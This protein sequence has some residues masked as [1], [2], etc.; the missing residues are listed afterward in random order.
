MDEK[1]I[2]LPGKGTPNLILGENEEVLMDVSQGVR[3]LG[4]MG[5]MMGHKGRLVVTNKRATLI[6]KKT[7]DYTVSQ[8]KLAL[9]SLVTTAHELMAVQLI[10]GIIFVVGGVLLTIVMANERMGGASAIPVVIGAII[11]LFL[12]FTAKRQGLT[13]NSSGGSIFFAS[14]SVPKEKLSQIL[15]IVAANE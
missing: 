9:T 10:V 7:K 14:K 12:I 3:D 2:E 4:L 5:K 15:T 1:V 8:I 11:G 6:E 13:L